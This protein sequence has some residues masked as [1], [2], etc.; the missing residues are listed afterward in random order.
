MDK[1][2]CLQAQKRSETLQQADRSGYVAIRFD[3]I[4]MPDGTTEKDLTRSNEPY[5][6]PP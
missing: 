2:L 4:Q 5:L 6:R 3:T 1:L